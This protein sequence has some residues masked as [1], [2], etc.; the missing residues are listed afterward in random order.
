M[1]LWIFIRIWKK[2]KINKYLCAEYT[3]E[4][5]GQVSKRFGS[6][7]KFRDNNLAQVQAGLE[8]VHYYHTFKIKSCGRIRHDSFSMALILDLYLRNR[9]Q[10]RL[11]LFFF[12]AFLL[13]VNNFIQKYFESISALLSS[14]FFF[15][16]KSLIFVPRTSISA[17]SFY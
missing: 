7:R 9:Q 16:K 5:S 15:F 13:G 11:F 12:L 4:S 6:V 1:R 8:G 3:G 14:L 2:K 17:F 10:K